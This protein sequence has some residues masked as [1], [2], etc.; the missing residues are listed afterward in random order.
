MTWARSSIL[1]SAS[2]PDLINSRIRCSGRRPASSGLVATCRW[3]RPSPR[4]RRLRGRGSPR[5]EALPEFLREAGEEMEPL[6]AS[7]PEDVVAEQD[8][9]L[10]SR[11]LMQADHFR[12][13]LGNVGDHLVQSKVVE[14]VVQHQDF[15]ILRN[16]APAIFQ[17]AD[18]NRPE[19]A[20]PVPPVEIHDPDGAHG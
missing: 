18:E 5:R 6:K 13:A 16:T 12:I 20:A 2:F 14:A 1:S 9:A 15:S 10:E 11:G 7:G 3:A 17:L 19:L 4:S 8:V